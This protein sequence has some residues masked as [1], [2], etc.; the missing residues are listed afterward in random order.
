[1]ISHCDSC[2]GNAAQVCISFHAERGT[3]LEESTSKRCRQTSA[4]RIPTCIPCLECV[5]RQGQSFRLVRSSS[6]SSRSGLHFSSGARGPDNHQSEHTNPLLHIGVAREHSCQFR[7]YYRSFNQNTDLLL[8]T[9]TRLPKP[10]SPADHT[11]SRGKP[12]H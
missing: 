6:F 1:V 12:H 9:S 5:E 4:K 3:V 2:S 10:S 11:A 7:S 8:P